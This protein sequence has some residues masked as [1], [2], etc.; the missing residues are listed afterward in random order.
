MRI[1]PRGNW[2]DDSGPCVAP[3][4]PEF[5]GKLD[6]NGRRATRLDL[7]RWLVSRQNPLVARVLV[8]RLWMLL[9]GQGLVRTWT[10]WARK[11]SCRRIR[12]CSIGWRSS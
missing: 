11:A 7:A 8:N 9:F 2:Q 6:V 1:L 12:S 10:I 3:A 5:L 4:I